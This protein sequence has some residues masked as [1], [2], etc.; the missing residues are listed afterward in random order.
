MAKPER[1][2]V[3]LDVPEYVEGFCVNSDCRRGGEILRLFGK[4]QQFGEAQQCF[5]CTIRNL[6]NMLIA[7]G[8]VRRSGRPSAQEGFH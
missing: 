2:P 1:E 5:G 3:R 7:R 4:Y 6:S 8:R